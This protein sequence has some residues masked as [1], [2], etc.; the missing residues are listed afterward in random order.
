MNINVKINKENAA[1][2]IGMSVSELLELRGVKARSSVWINGTQLLLAEYDGRILAEG[3]EI[4]ILR[5][6]AG[7]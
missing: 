1:L 3:D 5:V 2:P 7:G 6:V 4:K